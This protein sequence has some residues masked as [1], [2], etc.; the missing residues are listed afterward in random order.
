MDLDLGLGIIG[1]LCVVLFIAVG[2]YFALIT[3]IYITNALGPVGWDWWI[4]A[5]TIF[6]TLGHCGGS[7][8]SLGRD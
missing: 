6:G 5:I 8:I 2:I 7:L 3:T 4:V 1:V